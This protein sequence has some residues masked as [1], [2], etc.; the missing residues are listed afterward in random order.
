MFDKIF[1]KIILVLHSNKKTF[2][3]SQKCKVQTLKENN[4][5]MRVFCKHHGLNYFGLGY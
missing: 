4:T 2:F 5:F 1:K 3:D